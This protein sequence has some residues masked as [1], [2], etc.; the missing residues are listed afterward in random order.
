M[1]TRLTLA[2][3][4]SRVSAFFTL[5]RVRLPSRFRMTRH[6]TALP[7]AQAQALS[8]EAKKQTRRALR[9]D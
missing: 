5:C 7:D 6:G 4:G 9:V 3:Q 1:Y 2:A 8:Q